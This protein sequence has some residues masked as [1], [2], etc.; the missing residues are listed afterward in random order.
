MSLHDSI[1]RVMSGESRG[2]GPAALRGFLSLGAPIYRSA[3]AW[4]NRR[5]DRNPSRIRRL[6]K[7]VISIGNLTTGGTG[8]TPIVRWLAA[9]LRE[10]GRRVAILSRGYKAAPGT[11][12]DEQ[13]ML[14]AMLGES[15]VEIECDPDRHAAG[16]RV[17]ARSPGIDVFLLDDAF[18]H[19]RLHRDL[20]VVLLNAT[21]PFGHGH[22]LPRGLL[23]DPLSSLRRA[24][25]VVLTNVDPADQTQLAQTIAKARRWN[26]TCP[27]VQERHQ[28]VG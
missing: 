3:V 19:R 14:W 13:R 8:K 28:A 21:E 17:L 25:V 2:V 16:L 1:L 5:F 20:D 22:T 27:I 15:P 26:Q 24:G 9:A 4:R 10:R 23:R 12:G 7:P 18:Q 11:L 6:P